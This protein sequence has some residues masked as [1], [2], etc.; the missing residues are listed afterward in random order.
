MSRQKPVVRGANYRRHSAAR[1]VRHGFTLLEL[2]LVLAILVVL[3]GVVGVNIFGAQDDANRKTTEVQLQSLK[4][5]IKLYRL[6]TNQMPDTLDALVNGPSDATAKAKFG[7][8]IIESIPKDAWSNDIKYTL[9]G[10]SFELRS[11][12][13]DGQTGNDDDVVV[14]G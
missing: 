9:N 3:A 2:M 12:G 14:N 11:G 7:Q 1:M 6:K 5:N 10:S 8:P 4:D 13:P